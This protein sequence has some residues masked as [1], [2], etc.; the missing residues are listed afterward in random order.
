MVWFLM[1]L[2]L[3]AIGS[4]TLRYLGNTE[5]SGE[6]IIANYKELIIRLSYVT[7][8]SGEYYNIKARR[9]LGVSI[10]DI[11]RVVSWLLLIGGIVLCVYGISHHIFGIK[12]IFIG[13][14]GIGCYFGINDMFYRSFLINEVKGISR[15][16]Y[17]AGIVLIMI[18]AGIKLS[19]SVNN[20]KDSFIPIESIQEY[21]DLVDSLGVEN[22]FL[23][24]EIDSMDAVI[25]HT[26][27]LADSL[28]T[29]R[30]KSDKEYDAAIDY[31]RKFIDDKGS[32]IDIN[33]D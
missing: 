5:F 10:I 1:G 11:V 4:S 17:L 18:F 21:K 14:L 2:V 26:G 30:L 15:W 33:N 28:K 13:L 7:K 22:E 3:F 19:A 20:D 29:L 23:R 25:Y 12:S 24:E 27:Y 16:I 32:V 6:Y 31:L 9:V 8:M